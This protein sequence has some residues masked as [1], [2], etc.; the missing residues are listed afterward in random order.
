MADARENI[1]DPDTDLV[2]LRKRPGEGRLLDVDVSDYIR[3]GDTVD[4]VTDI[5]ATAVGKVV[6]AADVT[7]T[8]KS[9]DGVTTLQAKFAGGTD[10][11]NYKIDSTFVTVGGDNLHAKSMLWVR[12]DS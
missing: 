12:E 11:E 7:I 3:T 4:S 9:H 2:T 10:L 5:V 6:G 8:L 1:V